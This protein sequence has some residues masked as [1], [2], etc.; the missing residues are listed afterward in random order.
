MHLGSDSKKVHF[1]IFSGMF[2][3]KQL[4]G[5]IIIQ[6]IF[7]SITWKIHLDL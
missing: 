3:G 1:K 5:I 4:T 7:I 6:L 2:L